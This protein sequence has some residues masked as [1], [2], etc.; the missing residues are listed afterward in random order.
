MWMR[1]LRKR[2]VEVIQAVWPMIG[3][4]AA[5]DLREGK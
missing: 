2:E 5:P 3:R 4:T 1:P